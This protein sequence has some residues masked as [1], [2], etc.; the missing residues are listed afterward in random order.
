MP[1]TFSFHLLTTMVCLTL[2]ASLLPPSS[3]TG[4]AQA[5]GREPD[6]QHCTDWPDASYKRGTDNADIGV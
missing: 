1:R 6:L 2:F 3:Q 5:E 4:V